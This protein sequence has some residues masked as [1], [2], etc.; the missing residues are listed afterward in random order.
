MESNTRVRASIRQAKVGIHPSPVHVVDFG[1]HY[2]KPPS[3]VLDEA[4][5]P[6]QA[7]CPKETLP[8]LANYS[9]ALSPRP[10]FT[11]SAVS[12]NRSI[13]LRTGSRVVG[14]F[15]RVGRDSRGVVSLRVELPGS[16]GPVQ[17]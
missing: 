1:I 15:T 17:L 3:R 2:R 10:L 12:K 16:P 5:L 13:W 4:W 6:R 14:E 9:T 11:F 8:L 7:K